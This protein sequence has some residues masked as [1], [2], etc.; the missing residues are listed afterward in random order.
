MP[1]CNREL[2]YV[3]LVVRRRPPVQVLYVFTTATCSN[4]CQNGGNCTAPDTCSCDLGWTG[5]Q[6]ETGGC[7][8]NAKQSH[9]MYLSK[10]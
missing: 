5:V 6:C 7:M 8:G 1:Q 2:D 10:F 4:P 9:N 3:L